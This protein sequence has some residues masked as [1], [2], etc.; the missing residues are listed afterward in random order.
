MNF[1]G[2]VVLITGASSG[3]GAETALHFAK[4]GASLSITGRNEDNLKEVAKKCQELG[5]TKIHVIVAD[6]TKDSKM[7]I[8][9]TINTFGSLDVLVNN[10]GILLMGTIE[11]TS[12]EQYDNIFNVNVRAVY[13]L[14]MLA[15]PHLVKTKGSVVNVS[16]VCGLKSFSGALAYCMSKS[17]I[18][19]M[20][21]CIAL[22]LAPKQVRVNSVN[23]GV[24]ITEL[25]KRGGLNEEAYDKF[26]DHSK[27]THPL[28]RP[29][30]VEE[31]AETIIFLASD[32]ASFITG[33]NLPVDG[34]LN[35]TCPR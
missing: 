12:M 6:V 26:L 22:E 34:G 3:I 16:S 17:A 2:K 32:K 33:T 11:N 4:Y 10:A 30:N 8:E 25:Q 7:I 19:Q 27:E 18:D 14:T 31:V 35:A 20:T 5:N 13:E 24:I 9:S 28:G 15:V 23:P 1:A 21:K 29:G